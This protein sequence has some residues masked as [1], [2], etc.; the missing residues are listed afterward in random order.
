[1]AITRRMRALS[2]TQPLPMNRAIDRIRRARRWIKRY[3]PNDHAKRHRL[4]D[5][6]PKTQHVVSYTRR[7]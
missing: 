5:T 7:T 4:H 6:Q 2:G 3:R 1:M